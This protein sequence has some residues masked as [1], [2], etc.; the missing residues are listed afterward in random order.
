MNSKKLDLA[1]AVVGFVFVIAVLA[2]R[3]PSAMVI[4]G[5]LLPAMTLVLG[6]YF[7]QSKG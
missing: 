2:I 3:L 4:F 7:G 5:R 6:Y 1:F